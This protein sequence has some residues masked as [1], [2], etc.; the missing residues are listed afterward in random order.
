MDL[1]RKFRLLVGNAGIDRIAIGYGAAVYKVC[2]LFL[3]LLPFPVTAES[4]FVVIVADNMRADDATFMPELQAQL[5]AAGAAFQN[6]FVVN[7]ICCPSR[8]SIFLGRY[9]YN[10]GVLVNGGGFESFRDAGHEDSTIAAALQVAGYRTGLIGKYFSTYGINEPEYVP[11]G[12]DEWY[13]KIHSSGKFQNYELNENGTVVSYGDSRGDYSTDVYL[14]HALDFLSRVVADPRP[15]FL[16]VGVHAPHHP[17]TPAGRHRRKFRNAEAPRNPNFNELD[18]SDKP[19]WLQGLDVQNERSLDLAYR[20][21]LRSLLAVD[22]MIA[23][24]L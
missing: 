17:A 1:V 2:A 24:I 19:Q 23:S 18:M 11:P 6:G 3:I 20:N 7:A 10:H 8:A 12:W 21:R 14:G 15:F 5:V 4:N 9:V 22:E 13:G 16:Y